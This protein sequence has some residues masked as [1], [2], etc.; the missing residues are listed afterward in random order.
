VR[1]DGTEF[2]VEVG[3][4]PVQTDAG[5]AVL[6]TIVDLT[7][8]MR[9]SAALQE[10]NAAL[11]RS[12]LELERF[13]YVASHDL[14][15]PMRGIASF[16]EL[17]YANYADRLDAQGG[18]WLRRIIDSINQLQRLI[19]DLLEYARIG[20][21]VQPLEAVPMRDVFNEVL[22]LFDATIRAT[23][24]QV[25]CGELP[26]VMGHRSELIELL[27]NLI[28]NALKY[29]GPEP[30]RVHVSAE[31]IGGE[32]RF[33]VRDNG[34]GIGPRYH[35]RIFEIFT[36][37]H[38]PHEFPGTGI[39]L[40]ASRRIVHLHGGRIW[41]ESELGKGSVFRFTIPESSDE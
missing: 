7:E 28:D 4:N 35:E 27:L 10:A 39:G 9:Q 14:Q 29:H 41:V 21:E 37:L 12:N 36:R 24:A 2:G 1:K 11:K 40:A 31:R 13:A 20:A 33:S 26:T 19:R 34:I 6:A 22:E 23:G 3:L 16:A 15:T 17:L 32:W 8:R 30:P 38:G 5:T 25:T 18:D